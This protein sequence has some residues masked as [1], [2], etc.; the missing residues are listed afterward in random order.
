M[1]NQ[2]YIGTRYGKDGFVR[3]THGVVSYQSAMD[4]KARDIKASIPQRVEKEVCSMLNMSVEE[5]R[6]LKKG[7]DEEN[8]KMRK[9]IQREDAERHARYQDEKRAQE[10][11]TRKELIERGVLKYVKNIGLVNTETGQVVKL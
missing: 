8:A 9:R 7:W 10:S 2:R 1:Y 6:E 11:T 4:R 3:P 5:Y